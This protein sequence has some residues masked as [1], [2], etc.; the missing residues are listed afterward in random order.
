MR[1]TDLPQGV[2]FDYRLGYVKSGT[3]LPGFDV[4]GSMEGL[5]QPVERGGN[6]RIV[7]LGSC[8]GWAEELYKLLGGDTQLLDGSTDGYTSAQA[9]LML[10]RDGLLIKPKNVI[11]VCG[12][13][14]FA[15]KLGVGVN[16]HDAEILKNHPFATPNQ[17]A[18]YTA[19]TERWGLGHQGIY[20]GEPNAKPAYETWLEHMRIMN[21]LCEEF[22]I[23]FDAFLHPV[24]RIDNPGLRDYYAKAEKLAERHEFI[25]TL[26]Q[27]SDAKQIAKA[28]KERLWNG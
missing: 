14:D 24:E 13:Y 16:A 5:R 9:M 8:E 3:E 18:Y 15:Y 7:T 12:Y 27:A 21:G 1:K 6:T 23:K 22:A 17:I 11:C 2:R 19:I 20:Y 28:I 4:Y 26:P 10:I 25:R